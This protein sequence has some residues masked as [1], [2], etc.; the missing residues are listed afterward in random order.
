MNPS[1]EAEPLEQDQRP[2]NRPD[3]DKGLS[4]YRLGRRE[5][6]AG[7]GIMEIEKQ[8]TEDSTR[9]ARKQ[10][11]PLQLLAK[12]ETKLLLSAIKGNRSTKV[13]NL[14]SSR[15]EKGGLSRGVS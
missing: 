14:F 9:G 7:T 1:E 15:A 10:L 6:Q 12:R 5:T 4:G 13:E 11:K 8:R 2:R 3:R